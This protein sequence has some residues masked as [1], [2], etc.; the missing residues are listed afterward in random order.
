[1]RRKPPQ[2]TIRETRRRAQPYAP[3]QVL[4]IA[5]SDSGG[6]A[7]IEAD[8]KAIHANGGYALVAITSVT[9]QNTRAVTAAHDLPAEIVARQIQ[10][11]YDDF[12]VAAVKTGMLSSAAIVAIVADEL[13][14]R[15]G[16]RL[17]VDPVMISTSGYALLDPAA[18]ETVRTRLLPL[19]RV[20][21]PNRMEAEAL[22]G[23]TIGSIEEARA[24]AARIQELG[25]RAVLIKGGHLRADEAVDLLLDGDR[26]E[27]FSA[28]LL[29]TRTTHGTGCVLSAA[30][31]TRLAL[32]ESL[33]QAVAVAKRFVTE[34]IAHGLPLG[35]GHGPTDPF[36]YMRGR[37][38]TRAGG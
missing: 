7:G 8:L 9:A 28:P 18:V 16:E 10:T 14:R 6:G 1:M 27:T 11:V 17:V 32:G 3:P 19:A 34:A 33:A 25:P 13:E 21:T 23:L 15:G 5:G 4:T 20:C 22:S 36:F 31:A 30:L 35:A 26:W 24:A 29:E 38:W 37:D 2:V 12:E